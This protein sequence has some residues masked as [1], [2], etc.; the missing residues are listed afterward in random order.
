M[1]MIIRCVERYT[2][3]GVSKIINQHLDLMSYISFI[4]QNVI[5]VLKCKF[6]INQASNGI[7]Y[8]DY[9]GFWNRNP[10]IQCQCECP[11]IAECSYVTISGTYQG[12][13]SNGT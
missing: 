8:K 9:A 5:I 6:N 10:L 11:I 3:S 13:P 7:L 12:K 1:V 4:L 2:V